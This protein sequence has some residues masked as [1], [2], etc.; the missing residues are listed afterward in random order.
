MTHE[1]GL[2]PRI[3][4]WL[5]TAPPQKVSVTVPSDRLGLIK[6]SVSKMVV[7]RVILAVKWSKEETI[8]GNTVDECRCGGVEAIS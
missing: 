7:Q 8:R 6:P 3:C 5:D 4:R 1:A 2:H